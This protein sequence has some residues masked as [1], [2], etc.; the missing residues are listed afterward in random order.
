MRTVDLA[1]PVVGITCAIAGGHFAPLICAATPPVLIRLLWNDRTPPVFL[2]CLLMQWLY[3]SI[4][5]FY[6]S[7]SG[8]YP[9]ADNAF[10]NVD[11]TMTII[12]TGLV[13]QALGFAAV[14]RAM[15]PKQ[16]A[17]PLTPFPYDLNRLCW[18]SVIYALLALA[19]SGTINRGGAATF[20]NAFLQF[21]LVVL[22]LLV[23]GTLIHRTNFRELTLTG[24]TAAFSTVLCFGSRQS[25]F[26]EVV[27]ICLAAAVCAIRISPKRQFQRVNNRRVVVGVTTAFIALFYAGTMWE[28]QIKPIWRSQTLPEGKIERISEFVRLAASMTQETD[29]F[30]G[31]D[32]LLKRMNNMWQMSLVLERVPLQVPHSDGSLTW[33]AVKHVT[34]PRILFPDKLSL[35]ATDRLLA[36]TYMGIH[37]GSTASVGIGY[38]TEFYV[39][40]GI[41]GAFI[42]A[43]VLG[44]LLGCAALVMTNYSPSPEMGVAI[45]LVA[46]WGCFCNYEA[47][48]AKG[49]GS[50]L[51][52]GLIFLVFGWFLAQ[53]LQIRRPQ[54]NP[55][56]PMWLDR[57]QINQRA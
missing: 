29:L 30:D 15:G 10:T 17:R 20:I 44:A 47:N 19:L 40:F 18:I 45:T 6:A 55:A 28:S 12:M 41:P 26:K 57:S 54:F 8:Y 42:A 23:Y 43:F 11:L 50:F 21:R 33:M 3:T 25:A 14:Y 31:V 39:D 36:E 34:M 9:G 37:V 13:C 35:Q 53:F 46:L 24:L 4:N 27:L 38:V 52:H 22:A 7:W 56:L 48:L 16:T 32:A 2:A 5:V 1:C 51:S 49:L